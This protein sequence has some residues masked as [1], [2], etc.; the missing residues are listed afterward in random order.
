MKPIE[1]VLDFFDRINKRV[2][3]KLAVLM[4]EDH[5][6]IDSL[7][8]STRGRKR[9][10]PRGEAIIHSVRTA[11]FRMKRSLQMRTP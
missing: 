7:G 6:F 5:L 11:G 8:N 1:T 4:T 2:A 10:A 9:C 3:D